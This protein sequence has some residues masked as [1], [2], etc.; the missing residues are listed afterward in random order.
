MKKTSVGFTQR[1]LDGLRANAE[2]QYESL[3]GARKYRNIDFALYL[4]TVVVL[5]LG[6]R[7]FVLE[8]IRVD[9]SSMA[10][11]LLNDEHM[12]VEKVSYWFV[13]PA[14]GDIVICYYP[15]YTESCVKRVI[16]LPGEVVEVRGGTVYINGAPLQEAAYWSGEIY[17]DVAPVTVGER[18]LFVM[19]DNRN[20]SKDSRSPSVGCI[21]YGKVEGRVRAVIWP[22]SRWRGMEAET[23]A[24]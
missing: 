8:P 3:P 9:G 7:A 14:R 24:G 2:E 22:L 21:P 1:Q 10:P 19:G 20:G 15:G 12:F 23:Y 6:I 18:S 16:G 11:T 4:L 17:G 5:A 13:A